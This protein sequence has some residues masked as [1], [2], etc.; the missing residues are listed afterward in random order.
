[1]VLEGKK[2]VIYGTGKQYL[3]YKYTIGFDVEF[4][5]DSFVDGEQTIDNK[6]VVRPEDVENLKDY[7]IVISPVK[8]KEIEQ[9][10]KNLGLHRETNY[11]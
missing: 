3:R 2:I 5:L 10:L 4:F 7:F 11:I 9:K 8:K 1:M 6:R